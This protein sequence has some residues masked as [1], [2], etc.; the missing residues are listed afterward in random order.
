MQ[1]Q[2]V[3]IKSGK[4]RHGQTNG[5]IDVIQLDDDNIIH[6]KDYKTTKNK[7]YLKDDFF[8]L[9][10]YAYYI[11][12]FEDTNAQKIRASYIMLR[13]NFEHIT[14][15]FSRDQIMA[16]KDKYIDYA[17]SITQEKEYAPNPTFLCEWCDFSD[18]TCEA[19][20]KQLKTYSGAVE[21]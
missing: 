20:S 15:E 7:S 12:N 18:G 9:L 14:T 2:K 13:H 11:L 21:W 19:G 6:V 16:I 4:E 17:N 1:L 8:Q 10:T 3:L 5:F